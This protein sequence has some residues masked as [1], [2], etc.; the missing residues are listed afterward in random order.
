VPYNPN[1]QEALE[2]FLVLAK[3]NPGAIRV[4]NELL[5]FGEFKRGVLAIMALDEL[6]IRGADIWVAYKDLCNSDAFE[7]RKRLLEEP[8]ALQ[9]AIGLRNRLEILPLQE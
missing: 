1:I 8:E 5:T 9:F 6:G 3:G 7:L 4:L 2:A